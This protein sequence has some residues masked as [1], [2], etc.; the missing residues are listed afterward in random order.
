MPNR[1]IDCVS[2]GPWILLLRRLPDWT[3]EAH[4]DLI[5]EEGTTR[6]YIGGP[7]NH[8]PLAPARRY[9]FIAGGIGIAPLLP[10]VQQAELMGLDWRLLYGG[11]S[12]AS[13]AFGQELSTAHR[14]RVRIVPQ[15][16]Y[17]LLDL[18]AVLGQPDA[19]TKVC[20]CGPAPLLATVER[21]RASSVC[22]RSGSPPGP[23]APPSASR[24]SR[25]NSGAAG[26]R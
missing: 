7:R 2:H 8:F 13:M 3:P 1:L 23:A 19:D 6:Q 14:D 15:D 12:R 4:I 26:G 11:R 5:L 16:E 22:A 10:M 18:D 25:W 20:C 21:A 17:G 24:R 9:L